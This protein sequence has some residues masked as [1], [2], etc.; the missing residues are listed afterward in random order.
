MKSF[1]QVSTIPFD[2]RF[3]NFEDPKVLKLMIGK[4][5]EKHWK[6]T[7]GFDFAAVAGD[8]SGVCKI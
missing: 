2:K 7:Y 3:L 1:F 8:N 6:E 5:L 4:N